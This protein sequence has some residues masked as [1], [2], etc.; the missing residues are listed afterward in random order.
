MISSGTIKYKLMMELFEFPELEV[1][2]F[3]IFLLRGRLNNLTLH[4]QN[5]D[6]LVLYLYF[7][8]LKSSERYNRSKAQHTVI[9]F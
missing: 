2:E 9:N 6:P 8:L 3:W 7:L 1:K 4:Y 5:S